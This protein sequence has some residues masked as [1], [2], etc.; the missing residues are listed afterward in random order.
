MTGVSKTTYHVHIHKMLKILA[1]NVFPKVVQTP[2]TGA[3]LAQ[4]AQDFSNR[5]YISNIIGAID[6]THIP[7]LK[8]SSDSIDYMNRKGFYS[9]VFQGVAVGTTLQFIEWSGG[10]AGSV[11]DSVMFKQSDLFKKFISGFF[12]E[13]RLLADAAYGLYTWCL[14]PFERV[15]NMG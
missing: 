14:V 11:G 10:W 5:C 12:G 9:M 4:I 13:Y 6:G 7:I 1:Y 8:P 15:V 3:D 2:S